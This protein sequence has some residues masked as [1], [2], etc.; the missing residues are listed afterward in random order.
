M[1]STTAPGLA[2]TSS[3][4]NTQAIV[5]KMSRKRFFVP[6]KSAMAPRTGEMTATTNIAMPTANPHSREPSAPP[7]TSPWK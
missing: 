4:V 3:A 7:T 1:P 2:N 6:A 5:V